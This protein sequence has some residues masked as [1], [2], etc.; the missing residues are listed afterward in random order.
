MAEI[1]TPDIPDTGESITTPSGTNR[2]PLI[3]AIVATVLG[4]CIVCVAAFFLVRDSID[5]PVVESGPLSGVLGGDEASPTPFQVEDRDLVVRA[6]IGDSAGISVTLSTP[7]TLLVG[8]RTFTVQ[9]TDVDVSGKWAPEVTDE[10]AAVWA[11]GT[12]IN[13]VL[14]LDGNAENRRVL[15]G[16]VQGDE[17]RIVMQNGAEYVF[18]VTSREIVPNEQADIFRQLSPSV[19]VVLIGSE[20]DDRLIV[21]GSYKVTEGGAPAG[22]VI[23]PGN[24]VEMGDTAELDDLRLTVL[25]T[26]SLFNRPEIPAGF[27]FFLVDFQLQNTGSGQFDTNSLSLELRDDF[28]NQYALNPVASQLGNSPP[29]FGFLNPGEIR[30]ATAGYQI[31]AGLTS[32]T[33]LWVVGFTDGT[34]GEVSV[35]IPFA[36]GGGDAGRNALVVPQSADVSLDGTSVTIVGQITNIGEQ[37]LIVNDADVNLTSDGTLY[38]KLSTNPT[39]P[40]VIPP[41]QTITFSVAFQRPLTEQAIFSVLNQPFLLSGLR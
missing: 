38:L 19:T 25:G 29:L 20:S 41:G 15:E 13:Y 22:P 4:L 2:G 36:A 39:F 37:P 12:I 30:N 5:L 23:S 14:G 33:L 34:P 26:T 18:V 40:W 24:V 6:D 28:G 17:I 27:M 16:L 1:E 11:Y 3:I 8:G 9:S 32:P 31:P 35:R 10:D 21:R 7:V